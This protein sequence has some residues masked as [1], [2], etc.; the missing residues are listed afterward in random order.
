[1]DQDGDRDEPAVPD[2]AAERQAYIR[3]WG[4]HWGDSVSGAGVWIPGPPLPGPDRE[5]RG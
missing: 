4:G 2:A 1:M 3:R 5:E